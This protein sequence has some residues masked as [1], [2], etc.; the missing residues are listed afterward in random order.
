MLDSSYKNRENAIEEVVYDFL[1]DCDLVEMS[2][3]STEMFI[4]IGMMPKDRKKSGALFY[5]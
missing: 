3:D 4:Q 1:K 5:F 2:N